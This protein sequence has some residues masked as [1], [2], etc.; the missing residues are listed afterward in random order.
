MNVSRSGSVTVLKIPCKISKYIFL[1]DTGASCSVLPCK[2]KPDS[3]GDGKLYL[4]NG[5]SINTY[6]TTNL[7]VDLGLGK[8]YNFE[9]I[10]AEVNQAIL[11]IDFL[12]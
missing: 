5:T 8:T 3:E 10:K 9:F 6:G 12:T 7:T 1:I 4:P 11:G 2:R